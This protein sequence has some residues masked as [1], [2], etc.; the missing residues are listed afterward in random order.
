MDMDGDEES[1]KHRVLKHDLKNQLSNIVLAVSQL[2]FEIA[3]I[4]ED[5]QFYLK[6]VTDSCKRINAILDGI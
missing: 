6:A 5:Q 1:E 3:N 4:T 2:E